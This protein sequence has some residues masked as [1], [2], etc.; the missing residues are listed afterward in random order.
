LY[1]VDTNVYL[2][3]AADPG[4]RSRFAEFVMRYGIPFLSSVVVAEVALGARKPASGAAAA[5]SLHSV[6]T[7]LAPSHDDWLTAASA[8]ARLEAGFG[9]SRSFWNDALLAAQC[10]RLGHILITYNLSD[11]ERLQREIPLTLTPPFPA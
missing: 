11:F 5:R 1:A 9:K 10:A 8:V 6:G 7:A 3:A 4:V 2:E